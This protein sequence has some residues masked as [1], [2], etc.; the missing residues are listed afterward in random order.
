MWLKKQTIT[1]LNFASIIKN[2]QE[3][4]NT[5][6]YLNLLKIY[7]KFSTVQINPQ[8]NDQLQFDSQPPFEKNKQKKTINRKCH[9]SY[10]ITQ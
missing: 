5:W 7:Y 2:Y 1:K 9:I 10:F 6:K 8:S 4:K 3:N